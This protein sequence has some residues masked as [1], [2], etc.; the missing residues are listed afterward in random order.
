[1]FGR[2]AMLIVARAH[3]RAHPGAVV[4]EVLT[5]RDGLVTAGHATHLH[6]AP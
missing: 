2:N 6:S 3:T 5:F 1:M 4:S